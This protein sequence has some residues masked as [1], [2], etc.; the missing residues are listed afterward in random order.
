MEEKVSRQ[1]NR[2][3]N[4]Y[5]DI[6]REE[7]IRSEKKI[8]FRFHFRYMY[9]KNN[10]IFYMDFLIR[11]VDF[12]CFFM[13]ETVKKTW[14]IDLLSQKNSERNLFPNRASVIVSEP[15]SFAYLRRHSG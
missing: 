15:D 14:Q 8:Q 7:G 5:L 11:I 9:C 12:W 13:N 1:L 4:L 6:I 10:Y 2:E 3:T